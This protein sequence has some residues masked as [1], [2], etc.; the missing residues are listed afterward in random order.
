MAECKKY[1]L[2]VYNTL[3]RAAEEIEVSEEV[4][5]TYRRT[6]WKMKDNDRKFYSHEIQMSS[7]VGGG[8][9]AY[10][11]FREF[12]DAEQTSE[13][14][15]LQDLQ[16]EALYIAISQLTDS[17]KALIKALYFDEYTERE[18]AEITGVY[19]NAVHKRKM[20][21]LAKIKKMLEK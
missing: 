17:E 6:G 8:D 14:V 10:E 13:A 21:I 20:R 7:L 1:K 9:G 3:T 16:R 4:Y 15:V 2:T 12:T 11:N 19:H 18:Y 5:T